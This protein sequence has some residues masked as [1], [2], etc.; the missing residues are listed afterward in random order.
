MRETIR[1]AQGDLKHIYDEAPTSFENL[2]N[3]GIIFEFR[4][5]CDTQ[6]ECNDTTQVLVRIDHKLARKVPYIFLNRPGRFEWSP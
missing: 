2:P 6:S 4:D 3:Y 1:M 5:W